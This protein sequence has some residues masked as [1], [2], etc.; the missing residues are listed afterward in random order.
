MTLKNLAESR[1]NEAR[2]LISEIDLS[3]LD[4]PDQERT[5]L[6]LTWALAQ[7]GQLPLETKWFGDN[8]KGRVV[9]TNTGKYRHIVLPLP[10][11]ENLDWALLGREIQVA[12]LGPSLHYRP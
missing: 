12:L 7:E 1:L 11:E 8:R 6:N 10:L 4:I 9:W 5:R 3:G 2:I